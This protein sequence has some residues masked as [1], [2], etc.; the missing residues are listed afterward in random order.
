MMA[1]PQSLAE[2][3]MAPSPA[4]MTGSKKSKEMETEQP[5]EQ[6]PKRRSLLQEPEAMKGELEFFFSGSGDDGDD[7]DA[8]QPRPKKLQKKKTAPPQ[9][10]AESAM[11]PSPAMMA[12]PSKKPKEME[13]EQQQQPEQQ[14]QQQPS[15]RCRL[16][17]LQ[18]LAEKAEAEAPSGAF[19]AAAAPPAPFLFASSP[20]TSIDLAEVEKQNVKPQ[21]TVAGSVYEGKQGRK[22]KV[23]P[24]N[25]AVVV[26]AR[27]LNLSLDLS[28]ALSTPQPLSTTAISKNREYSDLKQLVDKA[29][30]ASELG[31]SFSGSVLAPV[32]IF[33][34][35]RFLSF[36]LSFNSFLALT[37][38]THF[39]LS[40]L[41]KT[42]PIRTTPPSTRLPAPGAP[43]SPTSSTALLRTSRNSSSSTSCSRRCSRA[44]SQSTRRCRRACPGLSSRSCPRR[45]AAS[46]SRRPRTTAPLLG[47]GDQVRFLVLFLGAPQRRK[48][49]NSFFSLSLSLSLFLTPLPPQT[50]V[51]A[52]NAALLPINKV[53]APSKNDIQASV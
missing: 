30:L 34:F 40:S 38:T 33:F 25:V 49:K 26:V 2:G 4:M 3:A 10:L 16:L 48:N 41:I 52:G 45:E 11:A 22:K 7:D 32:K 35:V 29:G 18:A 5:V 42:A 44:T 36:F 46:R 47:P 31:P 13:T 19:A 28:L 21:S 9:S 17:E 39:S 50:E 27:P 23:S 8:S 51:T 43:R 24:Q 14:Q 15:T 20:S 37:H 1:P 6:Q 12:A 53:L